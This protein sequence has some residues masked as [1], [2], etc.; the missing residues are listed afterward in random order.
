MELAQNIEKRLL[1]NKNKNLPLG[2]VLLEDNDRL[3]VLSTLKH[4]K[5]KLETELMNMPLVI[6]TQTQKRNKVEL[7]LQ[8]ED[9]EKSITRFSRPK[10]YIRLKD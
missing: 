10:V 5:E 8:L 7:E 4:S 2:L 1:E 6:Q 3:D 9:L